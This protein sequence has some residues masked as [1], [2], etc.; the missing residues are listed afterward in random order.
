MQTYAPD[1][2]RS[3]TIYSFSTKFRDALHKSSFLTMRKIMWLWNTSS[4][5]S[6]PT[7][8]W[9]LEM[10]VFKSL[11]SKLWRLTQVKEWLSWRRRGLSPSPCHPWRQSSGGFPRWNPPPGL[12]DLPG[13][14]KLFVNVQH[15]S[16]QSIKL[17]DLSTNNAVRLEVAKTSPK[18]YNRA[19]PQNVPHCMRK[20][21]SAKN[22]GVNWEHRRQNES[23]RACKTSSEFNRYCES[24]H[25]LA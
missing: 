18:N 19:I 1:K 14:V 9:I 12:P 20:Q 21:P 25:M 13:S 3:N 22:I 24:A 11:D 10:Q 2:I 8:H 17:K 6:Y 7:G 23:L 5:S 16:S 15:S 4:V